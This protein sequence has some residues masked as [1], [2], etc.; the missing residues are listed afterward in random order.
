MPFCHALL[1][2]HNTGMGKLCALVKFPVGNTST[3][4]PFR[5]IAGVDTSAV[6]LLSPDPG[7]RCLW[8]LHCA[9]NRLAQPGCTVAVMTGSKKTLVLFDVD[10]TLTLPRKVADFDR[11]CLRLCC[12][13]SSARQSQRSGDL[14]SLYPFMLRKH[15]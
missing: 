8:T 11:A 1:K 7:Q 4:R 9:D 3:H 12:K 13:R 15:V 10:G 5:H 6:P 2:G 14:G